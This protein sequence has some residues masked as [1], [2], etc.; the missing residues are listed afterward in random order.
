M[1]EYMAPSKGKVAGSAMG[2][3]AK[4]PMHQDCLREILE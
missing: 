1:S 3:G 4:Q 2:Q